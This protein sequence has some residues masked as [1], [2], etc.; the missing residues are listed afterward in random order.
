MYELDARRRP[1]HL[2]RL[3]G[4]LSVSALHAIESDIT[5]ILEARASFALIWDFREVE[6][7]PR[8]LI[9]ES[10][11][12]GRRLAKLTTENFERAPDPPLN[13]VGY[14]VTPRIA[15]LVNFIHRVPVRDANP[16]VFDSVEVAV[17]AAE[18]ALRERGVNVPTL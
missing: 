12:V 6:F 11:Q 10:L 4:T 9:T 2:G 16:V 17:V 18:Q 8:E 14:V 1:L 3:A 5:A 7:P 13:F 15:K